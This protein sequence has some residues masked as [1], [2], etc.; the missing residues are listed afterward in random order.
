[1]IYKLI[2]ILEDIDFG[3]E[4]REE[5]APV[6]AVAVLEDAEG[7]QCRFKMAD[8]LFVQ[9]GLEAGDRV[10]VDEDGTLRKAGASLPVPTTT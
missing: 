7:N 9:R 6:M 2:D 4:E 5:N 10:C 3:C 8:A 1:M